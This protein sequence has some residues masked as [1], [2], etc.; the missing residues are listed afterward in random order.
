MSAEEV[1][2]SK[3]PPLP[4]RQSAVRELLGRRR[5]IFIL[6]VLVTELAIFFVA[7]SIPINATTQQSLQ[8]EAK[9]LAG[10]T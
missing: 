9:N 8:N 1:V 3:P 7:T 10:T 2:L 4:P 6:S 5:L